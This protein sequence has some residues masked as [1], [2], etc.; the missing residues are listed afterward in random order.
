MFTHVMY[1]FS[2]NIRMLLS[3]ISKMQISLETLK[4][5]VLRDSE[6]QNKIY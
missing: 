4:E 2:T 3:C 1:S 5:G 6:T